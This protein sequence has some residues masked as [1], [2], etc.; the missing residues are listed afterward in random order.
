M[1]EKELGIYIGNKIREYRKRAG[2]NQGEL[3]KKVGLKNNTISAYERGISTPRQNKLFE[4]SQV[5]GCTVDDLFPPT[6]DGSA[7]IIKEASAVY[8]FDDLG[9]KGMY[10]LKKLSEKAL[11]LDEEDRAQFFNDLLWAAEHYSKRNSQ[12]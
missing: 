3:A 5:F 1:D 11:T 10:S 8:G 4:L 6:G 12:E 7:N 2:L 9:I